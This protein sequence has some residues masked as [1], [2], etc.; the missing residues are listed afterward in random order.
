MIVY[1]VTYTNSE[2]ES[3]CAYFAECEH[4]A[5]FGKVFK[6]YSIE[7]IV[8]HMQAIGEPVNEPLHA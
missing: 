2:G 3:D 4:A 5:R 1:R 8:V 6:E 7:C